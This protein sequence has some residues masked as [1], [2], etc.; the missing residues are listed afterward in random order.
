MLRNLWM[1]LFLTS[2]GTLAGCGGGDQPKLVRVTGKL[3]FKGQPLSAGTIWFSPAATNSFRG[4][5]PSCKLGEGGTFKM[6]TY[7]FG[8]GVPPGNYKV[9]LG[10][11]LASRIGRPVAY[12]GG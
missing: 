5:S 8:D 10:N 2:L 11:D 4:D 6:Q 7:P 12:R 1:A 9:T 3:T